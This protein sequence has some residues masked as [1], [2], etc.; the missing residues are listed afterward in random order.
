M[1]KSNCR[2]M[3]SGYGSNSKGERKDPRSESKRRL[4]MACGQR[5]GRGDGDERKSGRGKSRE[6]RGG[7]EGGLVQSNKRTHT[8]L[9]Q[10]RIHSTPDFPNEMRHLHTQTILGLDI[11]GLNTAIF[12]NVHWKHP[13]LFTPRCLRTATL[14]V[15]ESNTMYDRFS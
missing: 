6:K 1:D 9:S 13:I 7:G 11:T 12:F 3:E 15:N 14:Q 4:R 8:P 2:A 5:W 10:S